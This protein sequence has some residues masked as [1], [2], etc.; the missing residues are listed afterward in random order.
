MS[1]PGHPDKSKLFQL[2]P[3]DVLESLCSEPTV[4]KLRMKSLILT[5]WLLLKV[6][7]PVA[8]MV[9]PWTARPGDI[10]PGLQVT[11]MSGN[12]DN[13]LHPQHKGTVNGMK[14]HI[15]DHGIIMSEWAVYLRNFQ[16]DFVKPGDSGGIIIDNNLQ[17]VALI[18][19]GHPAAPCLCSTI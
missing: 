1:D 3:M 6:E 18:F 19:A 11:F 2:Q 9:H 5:D 16:D 10:V 8:E 12:H 4:A 15:V 7:R 14:V 17:P 13:L